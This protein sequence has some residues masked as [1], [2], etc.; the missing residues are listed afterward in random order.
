M[1]EDELWTLRFSSPDDEIARASLRRLM[2]TVPIQTRGNG[3]LR[4]TG[5]AIV[6]DVDE[7][8]THLISTV[9]EDYAEY[10]SEVGRVPWEF[11]Y[12]VG[13][14]QGN[15]GELSILTRLFRRDDTGSIYYGLHV[16]RLSL[17]EYALWID[18]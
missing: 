1:A 10:L 11:E 12:V 16:R 15:V 5:D 2:K 8:F 17:D 14:D 7:V 13:C 4:S 3:E 18:D 6:G 9:A